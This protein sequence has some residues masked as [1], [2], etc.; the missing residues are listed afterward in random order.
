MCRAQGPGEIRQ[1]LFKG[2]ETA[3]AAFVDGIEEEGGLAHPLLPL[4]ESLQVIAGK[5]GGQFAS[6]KIFQADEK[7]RL[8]ACIQPIR[9]GF[10]LPGLAAA[11]L[12]QDDHPGVFEN[13]VPGP[14]RRQAE[15][16]V[17]VA[18]NSD[19]LLVLTWVILHEGPIKLN[20]LGAHLP[21]TSE[22]VQSAVT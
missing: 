18:L 7:G 2:V 14:V 4:A 9:L 11:G 12:T 17:D 15:R 22:T 5:N 3:E 10:H 20:E 1:G 19:S 16:P 8:A 21:T 13:F 6:G